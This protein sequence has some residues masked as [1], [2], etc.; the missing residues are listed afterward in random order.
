VTISRKALYIFIVLTTGVL[1]I[2]YASRDLWIWVFF[3]MAFGLLW[4]FGQKPK[5]NWTAS[6]GL[7]FFVVAATRGIFLELPA[8]WLLLSVVATLSAWDLDHF[9]RRLKQVERIKRAFDLERHHLKRLMIIAGLG[10]LLGGVPI[11]VNVKLKFGWMLF[12]GMVLILSLSRLID[13]LSRE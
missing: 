2:G 9:V 7:I 4:L 11:V 5:W 8:G 3:I 1:A 13:L 12:L 6:F 10:L